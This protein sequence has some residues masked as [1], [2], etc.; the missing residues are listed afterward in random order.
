MNK[1]LGA[2]LIVAGT[3]IGIGMLTMPAFLAGA[4]FGYASL[5]ILGVW[6]IM[7]GAALAFAE[8]SWHLPMG[9]NMREMSSKTLGRFGQA[10]MCITYILLLYALSSAYLSS[11]HAITLHLLPKTAPYALYIWLGL[12]VAIL[13][14]RF[15][16][17]DAAN[18]IMM[19]IM[20]IS[21]FCILL[22]LSLS[23]AHVSQVLMLG[24]LKHGWHML[25][26]LITAFG[27]QIVVP[28]IHK[29]LDAHN[30][31]PL[32]QAI[33]L[34]SLIPLIFYLLW[35]WVMM[36][37]IDQ[38]TFQLMLKSGQPV[39]LMP[40]YLAHTLQANWVKPICMLLVC[41]AIGTSWLGVS[42]S[43]IDFFKD[44]KLKRLALPCTIVPPMLF[45]LFWPNG[46]LLALKYSGF[47]VAI[48]LIIL[49]V[50]MLI[51]YR[52]QQTLSV[53][54]IKQKWLYLIAIFGVITLFL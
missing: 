52:A 8:L 35:L 29:H 11:L 49:P 28:S 7:Y 24:E 22:G 41:A 17:L 6:A 33:L 26:L 27:F 42:L 44:S 16:V 37:Q 12:L 18:R 19:L 4:G 47:L 9:T 54:F 23:G 13:Q 38:A 50:V 21:F 5:C 46:F 39:A 51:A 30:P 36:Q 10:I 15:N 2:I 25:P 45:V 14:A 31:K 40:A 43:I 32:K 34:G 48:L 53:S 1:T 3:S 20:I